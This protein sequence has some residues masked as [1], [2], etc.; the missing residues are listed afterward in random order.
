VIQTTNLQYRFNT[1][2]CLNYPDWHVA[3]GEHGL[4]LGASGSGKTTLL[5][6]VSGLLRPTS[7]S[8]SIEGIEINQ[9]SNT[10]LD[11][12]RGQNIGLVF[13][14]PHLISALSVK[15]NI[16]LAIFLGRKKERDERI[17]DLLNVLGLSDLANR[18]IHEISQGQAQR[19]AIARALINQPKV[20]FGDEPTASLDDRSCDQVVTLLQEQALQSGATL[21][22]ATHDQ[23]V[24]SHFSN[25][26]EL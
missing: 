16:R 9:L 25:K 12:F 6:L 18:K 19:V 23:R 2:V 15:E 3:S 13:Q 10:A 5:H 7:G 11:Q 24:K 1:D 20:I 22:L 8:I 4:I 21:I 17:L 26:L 14:R